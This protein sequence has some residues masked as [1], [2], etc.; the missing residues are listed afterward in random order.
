MRKP[1]QCGGRGTPPIANLAEN[2]AALAISSALDDNG[3]L[4]SDA[5]AP[6]RLV[7][8]LVAKYSSDSASDIFDTGPLRRTCRSSSG[9]KKFAAAN[10]TADNSRP[11]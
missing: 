3:R 11:F 1:P 8:G 4:W 9:Q 6:I 7:Y 2:A 5:Q 10:G